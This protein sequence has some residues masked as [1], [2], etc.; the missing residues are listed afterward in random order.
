MLKKLNIIILILILLILV[1]SLPVIAAEQEIILKIDSIY[2]DSEYQ[3][4]TAELLDQKGYTWI[5]D[6]AFNQIEPEQRFLDMLNKY[7]KGIKILAIYEDY[8]NNYLYD[9]EIITWELY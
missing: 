7:L 8:N 5:V 2:Y 6:L 1:F 4:I 9:D 3:T